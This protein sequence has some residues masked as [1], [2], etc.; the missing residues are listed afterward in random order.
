MSGNSK[1]IEMVSVAGQARSNNSIRLDLNPF[2]V[3]L[4]CVSFSTSASTLEPDSLSPMQVRGSIPSSDSIQISFGRRR[5]ISKSGNEKKEKK[6]STSVKNFALTFQRQNS[7]LSKLDCFRS[8]LF[9]LD[10]PSINLL[11]T[12]TTTN[13]P[14]LTIIASWQPSI[15]SLHQLLLCPDIPTLASGRKKH[16]TPNHY[17]RHP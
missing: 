11:F 16:L 6:G 1:R 13:R 5:N 12:T 9:N 2:T 8:V 17:A 4:S 10:S 3:C 14:H 15:W 7:T